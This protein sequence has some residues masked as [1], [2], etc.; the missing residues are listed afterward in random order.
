MEFF[1]DFSTQVCIYKS[2][3]CF[4]APGKGCSFLMDICFCKFDCDSRERGKKF[5]EKFLVV[6][7]CAVKQNFHKNI[8]SSLEK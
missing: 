7:F 1:N 3:D 4:I 5:F 8:R 2:T 6:I